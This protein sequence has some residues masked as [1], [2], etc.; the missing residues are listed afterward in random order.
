MSDSNKKRNYYDIL[1]INKTATQTEIKNAYKKLA[2]ILHPDKGGTKEAFQELTEAY[3]TL[4]DI[5]QRQVYDEHISNPFN[6]VFNKTHRHASSSK[7][8]CKDVSYCINIPLK[9]AFEDCHYMI[10]RRMTK[11]CENCMSF[12]NA[13]AG[14][15]IFMCG[16][17]MTNTKCPFCFGKG[18]VKN[19]YICNKCDNGFKIEIKEFSVDI[20]KDEIYNYVKIYDGLGEQPIKANEYAGDFIVKVNMILPHNCEIENGVLVYKPVVNIKKLLCGCEID[21][22][23]DLNI[24]TNKVKIE[25]LFCDPKNVLI[26]KNSGLFGKNG[27]RYNINIQ[28]TIDYH[29]DDKNTI[30]INKLKDVLN[31]F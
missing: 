7:V 31:C 18:V 3:N 8:K 29:I 22:P 14:Y 11:V 25:P 24:E 26:I 23:V 2:I 1:C 13:C 17:R 16:R 10:R 5:Q 21:V 30:D 20:K 28:P 4:M 19:T 12:C 15:G 27:H 9:N 6:N